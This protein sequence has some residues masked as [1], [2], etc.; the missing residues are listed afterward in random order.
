MEKGMLQYCKTVLEKVSFDKQLFEKELSKSIR[1]LLLYEE[2]LALRQWCLKRFSKPY[3]QLIQ[4]VFSDYDQQLKLLP[5]RD[6]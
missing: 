6:S 3:R 2:I 4:K 5:G 1:T